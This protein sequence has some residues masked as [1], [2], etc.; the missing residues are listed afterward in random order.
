M[1]CR[2]RCDAVT[3]MIRGGMDLF[4]LSLNRWGLCRGGSKHFKYGR[5]RGIYSRAGIFFH[6]RRMIVIMRCKVLKNSV[7]LSG[8][9][10]EV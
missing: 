8:C 2:R 10:A 6:G 3:D 4:R 1:L 7:L 5:L 9:A